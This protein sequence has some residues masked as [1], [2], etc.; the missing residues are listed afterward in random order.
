VI[1]SGGARH[2]ARHEIWA[3]SNST[4]KNIE[5]ELTGQV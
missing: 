2:P 5:A 4:G 3:R 1:R